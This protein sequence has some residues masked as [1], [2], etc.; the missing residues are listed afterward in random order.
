MRSTTPAAA[1]CSVC[2]GCRPGPSHCVSVAPLHVVCRRHRA[3]IVIQEFIRV[4]RE[5]VQCR[6]CTDTMPAAVG[7]GT[8]DNTVRVRT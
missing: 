2:L 5:L 7:P 3:P 4:R 1:R 8:D 6:E